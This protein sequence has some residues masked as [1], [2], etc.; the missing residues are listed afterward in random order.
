M[1]NDCDPSTLIF[2]CIC[3]NGL[4]PNASEYSQTIPYYLCTE[5][6][7]QCVANCGGNSACQSACREQHPCGA[8]APKRVNTSSS[9]TTATATD[10]ASSAPSP[11]LFTTFGGAPL[12]AKTAN[13]QKSTASSFSSFVDMAATVGRGGGL[14]VVTSSALLAGFALLLLF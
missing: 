7:N 14:A 6:N 9:S 13:P 11:S 4:S 12:P 1:A 8:Q 5:T 2:H 3:S 10:A